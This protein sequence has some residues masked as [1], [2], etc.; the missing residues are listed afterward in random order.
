M[1]VLFFPHL[2]VSKEIRA[3]N[4]YKLLNAY[5]FFYLADWGKH[6]RRL[7]TLSTD[8]TAEIDDL[9]PATRYTFRLFA[10]ND[11]G[12]SNASESVSVV[13]EEDGNK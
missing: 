3:I 10:E 5:I 1:Y 13:T 9:L 8:K 7:H 12:L 2:I 6:A 11:V 4:T